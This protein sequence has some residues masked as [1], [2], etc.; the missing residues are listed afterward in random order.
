MGKLDKLISKF[1][2]G[3]RQNKV[4]AFTR[5]ALKDPEIR[6]SVKKLKKNEEEILGMVKRHFSEHTKK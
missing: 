2:D 1:F 3:L 6:K 5:D 4:N